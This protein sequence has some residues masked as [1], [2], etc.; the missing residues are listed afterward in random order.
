MLKWAR[1]LLGLE[2]IESHFINS[3]NPIV[4]KLSRTSPNFAEPP[5]FRPYKHLLRCVIQPEGVR[6]LETD[7]QYWITGKSGREYGLALYSKTQV[8]LAGSPRKYQMCI[9]MAGVNY[10]GRDEAFNYDRVIMEYLM[11]KGNEEQYNRIGIIS[12]I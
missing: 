9:Y 12:A 8:K 2:W 5:R 7:M 1:D 11:I 10:C 4:I 3:V 6:R